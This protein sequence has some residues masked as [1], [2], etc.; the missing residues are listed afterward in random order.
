LGG[1]QLLQHTELLRGQLQP[2]AG[3][4]GGA[5]ARVEHDVA[6]PQHRR[7]ARLCAAGERSD[8]CDQHRKV[9]WLGQ[10][11]VGAQ[12]ESVDQL[13]VR[14]RGGQH[15]QPAAPAA[16]D[17]PRTHLIAVK[18]GQI[19]IEHDHVVI[20]DHRAGQAGLAVERDIDSHVFVPQPGRNRLGQ[21]S[22]VFD[23]KHA[24]CC[25]FAYDGSRREVSTRFRR[26]RRTQRSVARP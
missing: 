11:V 18:S 12:P 20:V 22:V 5:P 9:E 24:H 19:A 17:E 25:S 1:E 4:A 8:S 2:Q 10:V 21:L 14:R 16:V 26:S 23:H 3:A 6:G 7:N 15:Q 13:V